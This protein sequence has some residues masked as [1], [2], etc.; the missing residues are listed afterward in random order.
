MNNNFLMHWDQ[1]NPSENKHIEGAF[2]QGNGY[3]SVRASFE[4]GVQQ[5]NQGDV[6]TRTF[7]SVTTEKQ[8][9]PITKWGTFIPTVMGKHP[10][11]NEVIINL[12]YFLDFRIWIDNEFVFMNE[13]S[14]EEFSFVL[15]MEDGSLSR[16]FVFR[17]RTGK[18]VRVLYERFPSRYCQHLFVQKMEF[19][20]LDQAVEINVESGIDTQV[21]TNGF[22]HFVK[23]EKWAEKACIRISGDTDMNQRVHMQSSLTCDGTS[24]LPSDD[25]FDYDTKLL[26]QEKMVFEKRSLIWTDHDCDSFDV[27]REGQKS[28]EMLVLENRKAW[29]VLWERSDIQIEGNDRDQLGVRFSIYHLLRSKEELETRTSICAKGFAGEAYY[30]RYFW[31]SEIFMLPFYLYTNPIIARNLLLYRYQTLDGARENA[32]RYNCR[33]ARFP[34]QSATT[35]SE[36]CS[37]WE[38]A[39]NEVHITAD[40]VYGIWH[41]YLATGDFK[42]I[43]QAGAEIIIETARFWVDRLDCD[44]AGVY[45][46]WNVMG[47]D[48]YTAF[49]ADNTFT[50]RMVQ[51]N[52]QKACDVIGLMQEKNREG[53]EGLKKKIGFLDH[54][55]QIFE[56][57]TKG[58]RI[59]VNKGSVFIPQ[60]DNF[61]QY[62]SVALADLWEDRSV[63]FGFYMTHEKLYRSQVLKQADALSLAMLFRSE[64]TVE[65]MENTYEIFEPITTHDS[66]LSPINH[67]I[68][69]GWIG[70]TDHVQKF[71]DYALSLDFDIQR[72]G[73]KDGIHIAN[74]GCIY[75]FILQ[76]VA[77]IETAIQNDRES[78]KS[79]S[80]FL[81]DG[82][83]RVSFSMMWRQKHYYVRVDQN[84][85]KI[86]EV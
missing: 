71:F 45:H 12:P 28:Y 75:Q 7:S 15:N 31:D 1:F 53:W 39:D 64:F 13:E 34:W 54:E 11:L 57:C 8:R 41:Y 38:Y 72:K 65:Q 40:I 17:T 30:G 47:P 29:A 83:K 56:E 18:C 48:E 6:Y 76:T 52:L 4:E 74:C 66:S 42:F 23:M 3:L 9:H 5:E 24:I 82:W 63:P 14:V 19:E 70:K 33:G 69:A 20:A 77:G 44:E 27:V 25:E 21:T 59:P 10:L 49:N 67:A 55:I 79:A 35:G 16:S 22:N 32:R 43:E 46:L 2:C 62:A 78:P 80:F 86:Q 73:S 81:P 85:V 36:Q 51:F 61:S 60:S 84:G 58:I 68:I 26:P 37:L 50:N